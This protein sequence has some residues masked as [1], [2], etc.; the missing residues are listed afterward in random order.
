MKQKRARPL[1]IRLFAIAFLLAALLAFL[2]DILRLDQTIVML[3][4]RTPEVD[5]NRDLAIVTL[6]A[7]LSIAFIPTALVWFLAS[8]FARWMAVVLALGKLINVPSA[9]VELQT[10]GTL[11]PFFVVTHLLSFVAAGCLF[12]PGARQWFKTGGRNDA[13]AFR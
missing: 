6:S 4:E 12:A 11:G 2:S 5:W 8:R 10:S 9:V 7:R 13:Q 1:S 3:R